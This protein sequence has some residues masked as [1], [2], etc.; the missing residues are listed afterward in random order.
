MILV[1]VIANNFLEVIVIDNKKLLL[2]W[3]SAFARSNRGW[4]KVKHGILVKS[5]YKDK[6]SSKLR[7]YLTD[8]VISIFFSG[9]LYRE[10]CQN[11][12]NGEPNDG[13]QNV[14]NPYL[15]PGT[16]NYN[17]GQALPSFWAT[18]AGTPFSPNNDPNW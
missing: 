16:S 4:Y 10:Y 7:L 2:G 9:Q 5:F 18:F 14:G 12:A 3:Q 11:S 1:I 8:N 15:Q 13:V 17:S 6:V